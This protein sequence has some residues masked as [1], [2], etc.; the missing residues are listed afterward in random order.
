MDRTA[1]LR[2]FGA[3]LSQVRVDSVT[4]AGVRVV[5]PSNL[6]RDS[7][8]GRIKAISDRGQGD[9]RND[10]F[11]I[12][13]HNVDD[14]VEVD[15]ID[16]DHESEVLSAPLRSPG[17]SG[18]NT[19]AVVSALGGAVKIAGAVGDDDDGRLLVNALDLAGV[20]TANISKQS[21]SS[22]GR[23]V[24]IVENGGKRFI[25][26]TPGA[27]YDFARLADEKV[28][29][30][31]A[32]TSKVLHLSSL[33]GSDGLALQ[34]RIAGSVAKQTIVSLTA[35]ALYAGRGLDALYG[36]LK[37]VHLLFLYRE[38]LETLIER[39]ASKIDTK[40]SSTKDLLRTYFSWRSD[41]LLNSP[42]VVLVKERLGRDSGVMTPA[43]LS[44]GAGV[45]SL[46]DFV[47]PQGHGKTIKVKVVDTTG[48]GDAAAG[49]FL[50]ALLQ[51]ASLHGAVETAFA[52]AAFA[53]RSLGA[54]SAFIK[55]VDQPLLGDSLRRLWIP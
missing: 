33:A 46:V 41:R 48:A 54:R 50:F 18:A 26:V 36:I 3:W 35:G 15:R 21:S 6:D 43:F 51:G 25:A 40:N 10:V 28:L 34:E 19:A 42:H 52:T 39:S 1:F 12:S 29:T 24:V 30:E 44:A 37:H 20:G 31:Q 16:A 13:A 32:S 49:G 2:N 23:A 47:Q 11:A 38:Q 4:I 8:L 45:G 27:N 22:T 53:S 5:I 14:L 7:I 55:G 9:A 17:G